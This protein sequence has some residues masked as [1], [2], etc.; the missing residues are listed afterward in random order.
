MNKLAHLSMNAMLSI[1]M[2]SGNVCSLNT[3]IPSSQLLSS[4]RS[5][6]TTHGV[7][8]TSL[9]FAA[10]MDIP[11]RNA[12]LMNWP[13]SRVII[14]GQCRFC[15]KLAAKTRTEYGPLFA[16]IIVIFLMITTAV[17][18]TE[19]LPNQIS[20]SSTAYSNGWKEPTKLP[21]ISTSA[22]GQ[23]TPLVQVKSHHVI[24]W[25]VIEDPS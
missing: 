20:H 9:E 18:A 6:F 7:S 12:K 21:G 22:L 1:R 23:E 24:P 3:S 19:S 8:I 25:P 5:L 4:L 17:R 14:K 13:L 16:S 2:I 10:W 11:L 15:S